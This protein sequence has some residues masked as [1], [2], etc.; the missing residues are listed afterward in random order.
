MLDVDRANGSRLYDYFLGGTSYLP[1]DREAGEEIA[2]AAP[3]WAL[4]ARLART[5][6]RRAVQTMAAAGVDQFLDLGSGIGA[7]GGSVHELARLAN[8]DARAVYIHQEPIAYELGRELIGDDPYAAV[9][10]LDIGDPDAV[11]NHPVT[12]GLIDFDRPVGV[13]V[14]GGFVFVPDEAGPAELLLRCREALAPGSCLA[15]SQ[16][17]DDSAHAEISAELDWVRRRYASTQSP[18]YVRPRTEI[19]SWFDGM[20]LVDPGLVRYGRWRPEF[21]LTEAQ[22]HCDFG[23]VGLARVV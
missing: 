20:E 9:L 10:K 6:A 21:P 23:Y 2:R 15:L 3:H 7:G 12:R 11:L 8:P 13:L 1:V 17:S 5:F 22:L 14:V 16:V 19:A 18:L 4:G